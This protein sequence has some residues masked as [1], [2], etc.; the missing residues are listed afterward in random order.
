MKQTKETKTI[1]QIARD[2]MVSIKAEQEAINILV[3]RHSEEYN[4][5][6]QKRLQIN[7]KMLFR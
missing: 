2:T 5:I 1:G 7:K 6:F 3:G 4:A